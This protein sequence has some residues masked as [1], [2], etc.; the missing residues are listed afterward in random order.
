MLF[1][2]RSRRSE[3]LSWR[4]LRPPASRNV[5]L[6]LNFVERGNVFTMLPHGFIS[7]L[8]YLSMS[9]SLP[10]P[11]PRS[12]F[13]SPPLSPPSSRL[14][15]Y[16]LME[17]HSSAA[18]AHLQLFFMATVV[19]WVWKQKNQIARK[20]GKSVSGKSGEQVCGSVNSYVFFPAPFNSK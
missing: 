19:S 12:L 20:P 10:P 13:L 7:Y 2:F 3:E 18:N 8:K 5:S 17:G 15:V 6:Q 14:L 4:N 11:P 1:T 9:L 16:M